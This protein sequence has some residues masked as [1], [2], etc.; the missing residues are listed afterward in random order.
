[1]M[2]NKMS[3][4]N[5]AS[6][7]ATERKEQG[8][9]RENILRL[10]RR[11]GEMTAIELSETL[12]IGAVGVRQHLALLERDG[13]VQ[14]SGLRRSVGRPSHLY[15]LTPESERY[16]PKTYAQFALEILDHIADQYG[17]EGVNHILEARNRQLIN[18]YAPRLVGKSRPDQVAE[19]AQILSEQGYMCE[20]EQLDDGS[21]MLIEYNCP[22]DCVARHHR[23]V[24]AQGILFYQELLGVTVTRVSSIADGDIACR[25]HIPA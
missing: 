8:A 18:S 15:T 1:M 2:I 12:N 7:L 17:E 21:F 10:L 24:C 5:E 6:S 23:Q 16:F 9:T 22:I 19:L 20:Y 14:V 11:N 4:H 13:L 25:Y 3:H